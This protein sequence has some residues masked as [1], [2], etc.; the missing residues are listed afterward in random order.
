MTQLLALSNLEA[1]RQRKMTRY[2]NPWASFKLPKWH[3]I[4]TSISRHASEDA[5]YQAKDIKVVPIEVNLTSPRPQVIWLGHASVYLLLPGDTPMG[6]LF[7]PIFSNRSVPLPDVLVKLGE[8]LLTVG[9]RLSN[10]W[11]QSVE[12]QRLA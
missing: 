6:I 9:A 2:S 7:D 11:V 12:C 4:F 8:C 3:T 10:G 5:S 1:I